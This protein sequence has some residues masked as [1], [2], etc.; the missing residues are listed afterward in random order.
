[1]KKTLIVI[2]TLFIICVIIVGIAIT[3]DNKKLLKVKEFNNQYESYLHKEIY[4]TDVAT[5]INKIVDSNNKNEVA[6]SEEGLFIENDT[7][8]IK[9][10]IQFLY[11]EEVIIHPVEAVYNRGLSSF[12]GNFNLTKFKLIDIEYHESTK[13]ISKMILK[14]LE[15]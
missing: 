3:E 2:G 14:Q 7:N 12:I 11:D 1:M 4:G 15:P 6:K 5:I 10:E 8:S 9:A 13:Q